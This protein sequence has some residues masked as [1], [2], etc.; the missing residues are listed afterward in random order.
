ME[1]THV[2]NAMLVGLRSLSRPMLGFIAFLR[3]A[4]I[5][6]F[7]VSLTELLSIQP[8]TPRSAREILTDVESQVKLA[9]LGVAKSVQT[10]QTKSGIKDTYTQHWID[11]LIVRART[12]QK[13]HPERIAAD[14][15]KELLIWVEE[16]KSDIYNPFLTLDGA[17]LSHLRF[18]I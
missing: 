1:T 15:Q 13:E 8:S 17:I 12:L 18:Y 6:S 4:I 7:S 16:H 5:V 11:F 2:E 14:I 9:C 3:W 10:Q